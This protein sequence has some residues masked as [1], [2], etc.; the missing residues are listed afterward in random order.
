M[1]QFAKMATDTRLLLFLPG[2]IRNVVHVERVACNV[3]RPGRWG[4]P[5]RPPPR[6]CVRKPHAGDKEFILA[7]RRHRGC[8]LSHGQS[9][10]QPACL[11][12]LPAPPVCQPGALLLLARGVERDDGRAGGC[13]A[14]TAIRRV[15]TTIRHT[16]AVLFFAFPSPPVFEMSFFFFPFTPLRPPSPRATRISRCSSQ[17]SRRVRSSVPA[18][19]RPWA[20]SCGRGLPFFSLALFFCFSRKSTRCR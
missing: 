13:D 11:P 7:G 3:C 5:G 9:R 19:C 1:V 12:A 18:V 10:G 4:R 20:R 8:T 6:V 15:L 17:F 2:I 16:D 14:V